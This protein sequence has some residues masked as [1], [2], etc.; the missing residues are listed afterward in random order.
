M[1]NHCPFLPC[2]AQL[3]RYISRLGRPEPANVALLLAATRGVEK[4]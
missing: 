2:D 3:L 1:R 4:A